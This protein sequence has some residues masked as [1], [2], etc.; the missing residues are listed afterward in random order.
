MARIRLTSPSK[1]GANSRGCLIKLAWFVSLFLM[2]LLAI[3]SSRDITTGS[4]LKQLQAASQGRIIS[5][6]AD[7]EA[8]PVA[9]SNDQ[10]QSSFQLSPF[11]SI[12]PS[13]ISFHPKWKLWTEMNTAQQDEAMEEV[14]VYIK[15]Y[16]AMIFVNNSVRKSASILHSKKCVLD[17][18]IGSTGHKICG[19][20][21]KQPC[22]F[23]SFGINDDPSF[24]REMADHWG[25]RGFAG[26]PTVRH[27]SKLHEKVTFH[28]IGASMLQ[29]NEERLID[30]GGATEWWTTSM[31]KLRYFLG[32][33][34]IDLLKIDCEGCEMALA[35]DIIRED[36]YYLTHVDQISIETHVSKTWMTTREHV[37]YFGLMFPLLEEAGFEM[38]WSSVFGCS[39]RHEVQGCMPELAQYGWPCGFKPWPGKTTVVKGFSCQEFTWKR[40]PKGS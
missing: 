12:T 19:P 40:Y 23:I 37:Y 30:K 20:I 10:Q 2:A 16:G 27:P 36:P 8:L 31:P 22:T 39:K 24:D 38:E 11:F 13:P 35:R 14:G 17:E 33:E 32:L 28:N 21:P 4:S 6:A 5:A 25:C 34:H 15:K 18:K 26:D 7:V 1:R 3:E 29:D 9:A